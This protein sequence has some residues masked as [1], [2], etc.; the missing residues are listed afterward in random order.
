MHI[1]ASYKLHKVKNT[2]YPYLLHAE[3]N[4]VHIL[5]N[6]CVAFRVFIFHLRILAFFQTNRN[7]LITLI[8]ELDKIFIRGSFFP[9]FFFFYIIE[10]IF[11]TA[12]ACL[13]QNNA[14]KP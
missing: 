2:I 10:K 12:F 6:A 11:C 14:E 8:S 4:T 1:I 9:F 5:S 13:P 3:P 7:F